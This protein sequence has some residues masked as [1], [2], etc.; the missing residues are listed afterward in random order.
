VPTPSST[1]AG[2]RRAAWVRSADS[3]LPQRYAA[4][5]LTDATGGAGDGWVLDLDVDGVAVPLSIGDGRWRESLLLVDEVVL[6]VAGAGGWD[7]AGNFRAELRLI[8]TPHRILVHGRPAG[9]MRLAWREAP[10][11]GA[12]PATLAVRGRDELTVMPG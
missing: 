10:L 9:S 12:D 8:E 11:H 6:P 5:L 7:A 4:G 2:P 1:A 3:E